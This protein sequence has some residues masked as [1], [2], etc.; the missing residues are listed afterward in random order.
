MSRAAKIDGT[1]P[2]RPCH[3]HYG[4]AGLKRLA[5]ELNASPKLAIHYDLLDR[6]AGA[7]GVNTNTLVAFLW[8]G[9]SVPVQPGSERYRWAG[10]SVEEACEW[11]D[12][13]CAAHPSLE[14]GQFLLL[15]PIIQACTDAGLIEPRD[16]AA[17]EEQ[18]D[19]LDAVAS[20]SDSMTANPSNDIS[21]TF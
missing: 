17:E 14:A 3:L 8:A 20:V 2:G 15:G 18:T 5:K 11:L 19:P 12:E 6:R 16:A 21:T 7:I 13:Y 9:L 4:I 1:P 10:L